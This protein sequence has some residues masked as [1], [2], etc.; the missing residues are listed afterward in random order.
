MRDNFFSVP[1]KISN[2]NFRTGKHG[3]TWGVHAQNSYI[4]KT[5]GLTNKDL[6]IEPDEPVAEWWVVSDDV[7]FPSEVELKDGK[8]VSLTN[9]LH[10][11][12]TEI[13]GEK[14][15]QKYGAYLGSILKLIDP[16]FSLSVRVHPAIGH[17]YRPPKP[18]V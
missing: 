17:P 11:Y 14:H 5:L 6:G 4:L 7:R 2:N 13:L 16:A 8:V 3:Y 9:I 10:E 15:F 1:L 12:P 18:E